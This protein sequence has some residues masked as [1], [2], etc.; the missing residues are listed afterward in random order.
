MG[1][2]SLCSSFSSPNITYLSF[3]KNVSSGAIVGENQRIQLTSVH[4]SCPMSG[5][6][7]LIRESRLRKMKGMSIMCTS[8]SDSKTNMNV[9]PSDSGVKFQVSPRGP[10]GVP[11]MKFDGIEPFRGKSGSVSFYGL[12]HQII[13]ESKLAS[14]PYKDGGG[15]FLWILA[16]A[17]LMLSFALPQLYVTNAV[18][19]FFEDGLLAETAAAL[20]SEVILYVGFA[21]FLLITDRVQRPYLQFS[22]K[23]WSLITGLKGFLEISFFTMGLKVVALLVITYVTW[24]I[25]RSHA[26]TLIAP[27]LVGYVAQL[28][29]ENFADRQ[30]SSCWPIVP[31]IFEV[32]R[33]YQLARGVNF[34][35]K[36]MFV[37]GGVDATP[38]IID[39]SRA[40]LAVTVTFEAVA[41][42]CLW[43]LLTFLVRL[44]PSRP[45]A[46]KY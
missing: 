39:R 1:L 36:L 12:T 37:M 10:S 24:P 20:A 38:Q 42:V 9:Q 31:I 15:S 14:S 45:V 30:G 7:W 4:K 13:E 29:L 6:K 18:S 41:V 44:F 27:I 32:Y 19:S 46:E 21:I 26:I 35:D 5:L 23:R 22:A 2:Q 16:P 28:A 40:L 3:R 17:V 11:E 34:V 8:Q 43:S 25:L 33:L